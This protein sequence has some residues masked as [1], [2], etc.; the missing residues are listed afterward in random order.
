TAEREAERPVRPEPAAEA[1]TEPVAVEDPVVPA[2]VTEA[3]EA[4][5][6]TEAP[7]EEA[8]PKGRTRRRA[9]RKVSA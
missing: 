4:T 8:A 1:Q 2:A 7:A 3:P 9:T 5:E 6:A